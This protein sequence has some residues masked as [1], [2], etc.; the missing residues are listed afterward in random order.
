MV[1]VWWLLLAFLLG[2]AFGVFL[3]AIISTHRED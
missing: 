1:S 2:A 3:L